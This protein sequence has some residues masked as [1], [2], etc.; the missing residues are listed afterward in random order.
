[1]PV[2]PV[3]N[4]MSALWTNLD[5][6]AIAQKILEVYYWYFQLTSVPAHSHQIISQY[7]LAA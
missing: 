1:M 6:I 7:C 4:S 5:A 3:T 2:V